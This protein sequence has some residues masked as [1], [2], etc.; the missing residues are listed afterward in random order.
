MD[1]GLV[2]MKELQCRILSLKIQSQVYLPK[3]TFLKDIYR[4]I[5]FLIRDAFIKHKTL[6]LTKSQSISESTVLKI[7]PLATYP[8]KNLL[9]KLI[10][11]IYT[12]K[13]FK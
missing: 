7:S 12:T 6:Q 3:R 10:S 9:T 13:I 2:I 4:L 8:I 11:S 5:C 1:S